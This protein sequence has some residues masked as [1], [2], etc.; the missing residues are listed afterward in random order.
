MRPWVPFL[1]EKKEKKENKKLTKVH[2]AP[3]LTTVILLVAQ[4]RITICS[5]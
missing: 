3:S 4:D 1:G 2:C 5:P